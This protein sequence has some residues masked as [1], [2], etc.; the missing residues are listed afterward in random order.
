MNSLDGWI[1]LHRKSIDSSAFDNAIIWKVWCWCLLKASYKPKLFPFNG[2]DHKLEKGQFITGMYSACKST[3]LTPQKYRTAIK[4]L[5]STSRITTKSNNKF[6]IITVLNWSDYQYDNR[7]ANKPVT[8]EQ[9]TSN[10]PITTNKKE[11]KEK[12]D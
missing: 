7:P 6:T 12:K 3:K 5:K 1:R 10:K 8:N 2:V 4:Y 11:K 9:Q